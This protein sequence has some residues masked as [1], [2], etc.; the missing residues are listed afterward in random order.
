[1]ARDAAIYSL[2]RPWAIVMWVALA[3]ALVLSILN[4]NALTA[5]GVDDAGTAAWM[6]LISVALMAYAVVLTVSGARRAVRAVMPPETVVW[7]AV[8]DEVLQVGAGRRTSEI[9]Y[10]TFQSIRAGRDAV[11]LKLRGT[12][13]A[14][15]IP[16]ALLTDD[17]IARLRTAIG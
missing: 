11:I 5:A 3:G 16:R 13:A 10:D 2:T 4:L 12:S 15:A 8:G 9:R 14:T 17:E 6:P 1:M 7:V